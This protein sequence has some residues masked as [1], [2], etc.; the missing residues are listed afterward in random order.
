MHNI[1]WLR[2][3]ISGVF[4]DFWT[5]IFFQNSAVSA[6]CSSEGITASIDFDGNFNGKIYSLDYATVPDCLYYNNVDTD[7]VLFSIPAHRCGTKLSRTTR[8]VS[9]VL[10]TLNNL[11]RKIR[12]TKNRFIK[13]A[14]KIWLHLRPLHFRASWAVNLIIAKH[15][16][17]VRKTNRKDLQNGQENISIEYY[18]LWESEV[19]SSL[20]SALVWILLQNHI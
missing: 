15:F 12:V 5:C 4:H 14:L 8:N 1:A 9:L 16:Q 6:M 17:S 11:S 7:T 19:E 20:N 3:L 2:F 18:F 13:L 10:L